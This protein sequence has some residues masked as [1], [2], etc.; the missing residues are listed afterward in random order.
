MTHPEPNT[1][2]TTTD[3]TDAAGAPVPL[4][5]PAEIRRDGA[6]FKVS[7]QGVPLALAKNRSEAV[8]ALC[9]A[10]IERSEQIVATVHEGAG[11]SYL[12]FSPTGQVAQTTAPAP[13]TV[14]PDIAALSDEHRDLG[15]A[16][17][18]EEQTRI[19]VEE[20]MLDTHGPAEP[21]RKKGL[22]GLL[23]R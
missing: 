8:A 20:T 11:R 5:T 3:A 12:T 21:A 19:W 2:P 15:V 16:A 6:Q 9:R 22:R 18:S 4:L 10:A 23:G 17:D 1:A 13:N 7:I 14:R